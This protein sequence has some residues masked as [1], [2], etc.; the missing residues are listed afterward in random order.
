[1]PAPSPLPTFLYKILPSAPPSPLPDRLPLSELD[2]KDGFIHLS[3]S[4][5]V[6][7]T[8]D[9]F[10][11]D[12]TE[13]WLLKIKYS[14]LE[15]GT[16]ANGSAN[17]ANKA[18]IQW[19]EVG[20]GA[21]A[22]FYGGDLGN[23]NVHEAVKVEKKGTWAESLN[24]EWNAGF[25]YRA[26][27]TEVPMYNTLSKDSRP[28]TVTATR[29]TARIPGTVLR[30]GKHFVVPV[31]DQA[32]AESELC[33]RCG[34]IFSSTDA[35]VLLSR[36]EP[37]D[38]M[39]MTCPICAIIEFHGT[40]HQR[41]VIEVESLIAANK[42]GERILNLTT[43]YENG[44]SGT[45]KLHMLPARDTEGQ[46]H[47]TKR[48]SRSTLS[49]DSIAFLQEQ[50]K[51]CLAQHKSCQ[52]ERN[53]RPTRLLRI[54]STLG[55]DDD[56]NSLICLDDEPVACPYITLSHCW[57]HTQPLKLTKETEKELRVGIST[58]KLPKTF[59]EAVFD[60]LQDWATEAA[61]MRTVY[62]HAVLNIAA[63]GADDSTVGLSFD[64]NPLAHQ[65]FRVMADETHW[66]FPPDWTRY[67]ISKSPLNR[68]AWVMQERFLSGR[69]IHF[70]VEGVYW[71][72]ATTKTTEVYRVEPPFR[73]LY[74]FVGLMW[75]KEMFMRYDFENTNN[76]E[77]SRAVDF[78]HEWSWYTSYRHLLSMYTKCGITKEADK[79]VAFNAIA[80]TLKSTIGVDTV[81][82]MWRNLFIPELLWRVE[83]GAERFDP[84]ILARWRAPSWS[85]ASAD[86][87]VFDDFHGTRHA[88]CDAHEQLV[89]VT[90]LDQEALPS[91][92]LERASLIL[93]GRLGH[94][95]LS[96]G[97]DALTRP[98]P[99]A[100]LSST[101]AEGQIDS[102]FFTFDRMP[103]FPYEEELAFV[104]LLRCCCMSSSDLHTRVESKSPMVEGLVLRRHAGASTST[105]LYSRVGVMRLEGDEACAFYGEFENTEAEDIVLI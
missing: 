49:V 88:E 70:T 98:D 7:G 93:L 9:R 84:P 32:N 75:S 6:P 79:L 74:D 51:L 78:E 56:A 22:H 90:R 3:T 72:C 1:M 94:A 82:G 30:Q 50:Y 61:A 103:Q 65:P 80:Q 34:P 36:H 35:Q 37:R 53:T 97:E 105:P 29:S 102:R 60:N 57:G 47:W 62:A 48:L 68:R 26:D 2:R 85:W 8:A 43:F 69:I 28:A 24:L 25:L 21:F 86:F 66:V 4:E 16:D 5:Q 27:F 31:M 58:A 71:D 52:R 99:L 19:D 18:W 95:K 10:F 45:L 59:Q 77:G 83:I 20:H 54:E 104:A 96:I 73:G 17:A 91:G 63:T 81:C 11:G 12:F 67:T 39:S 13:L 92:Q 41:S 87:R 100:T 44:D 89:Q 14:V 40:I 38:L 23:G 64:R 46:L 42:R 76:C 101:H 33:F 15:A 55:S